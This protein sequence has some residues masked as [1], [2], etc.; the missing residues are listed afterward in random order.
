MSLGTKLVAGM[1]AIVATASVLVFREVALRERRHLIDAKALAASMV[2]DLFALGVAAPL[3]FRDPDAAATELA[4]LRQNGEVTHAAVW[5]VGGTTPF[6]QFAQ[7]PDPLADHEKPRL[8][9]RDDRV[10]VVRI[11]KSRDGK[12][13]GSAVVYLSLAAENAAFAATLART[14]PMAVLTGLGMLALLVLLVRRQILVPLD[15]LVGAARRV[16]RGEASGP[17]ELSSN[18]EIGRLAHAFDA[19]SGAI[20]DREAKLFAANRSLEELFD[21]MRQGIIVFGPDGYVT[22]AASRRASTLFALRGGRERPV[23]GARVVDLLYPDAFDGD[24]EAA[25]WDQWVAL[26][27][28][29]PASQWKDIAE[30]APK[31]VL[32]FAGEDER[33]L[34]LEVR[35][36]AQDDRVSRVMLLASDAT[37]RRRLLLEVQSQGEAHARE[38]AALRR[39]V[40]GGGQAL[41]DFLRNGRERLDHCAA[42][43]DSRPNL[44]PSTLAAVLQHA[45]TMR[46]EAR[47]LELREL[48]GGLDEL[49]DALATTRT[50][51]EQATD[52]E[53]GRIAQ[54]LQEASASLERARQML[55]AASP[56][57][58][59]A[60][61]QATVRRHDVDRL[62]EIAGRRDGLLGDIVRRLASRPFGEAAAIL[63]MQAPT[64]ATGLDKQVVVRVEGR[65]VLVPPGLARVLPGVLSHLVRNAIAHGIEGPKERERNAKP[66][67]GTILLSCV[68]NPTGPVLAVEDDGRGLPVASI[69]ARAKALGVFEEGADPASVI[70]R[71]GFTTS[72]AKT[73]IA[74]LGVGLSAAQADLA[75][76]GYELLV[77][78]GPAG[79]ARFVIAPAARRQRTAERVGT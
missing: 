66:A 36:M 75:T 38:M 44:A 60:L 34:E 57:G 1:M 72:A 25:A 31:E 14:V 3:D 11:V 55:I 59:A 37:D 67:A 56:L 76:A 12:P 64:W 50:K 27:F 53:T 35:P 13:V 26:A 19:M 45:H 40:A 2:A 22:S 42:L 61:D 71:A 23:Q 32:L 33:L 30:L 49:E 77:E 62:V 16:E 24:P 43:I 8:T 68:D 5:L 10:E 48:A 9:V 74:G 15:R 21:S 58:E 46:G 7:P 79:G 18:D 65:D 47:I 20:F 63:G 28:S 17:L 41:V 52:G 70:L 39:L 78:T 29:R 54:R 73:E 4:N 51:G 6:A 69:V